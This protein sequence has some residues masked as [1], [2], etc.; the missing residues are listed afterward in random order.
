MS[1]AFNKGDIVYGI[2]GEKAEYIIA[3][4]GGHI[5]APIYEREDD[6]G[7]AMEESDTPVLWSK[8]FAI[9]PTEVLESKIGEL[10]L[11]LSEKRSELSLVRKQINEANAER[12]KSLALIKQ[13]ATLARIEEYL[14]GKF[15]F[16][17]TVPGYGKPFITPAQEA[18][19]NGGTESENRYSRP[20]MKLLTLFGDSKGDLSWRI[21]RYSDGSGG[22]D[23]VIPCHNME[24]AIEVIRKL[25]ADGVEAWRKQEKKHYGRA[26]DWS[27]LDASWIDVPDDVRQ[28]LEDTKRARLLDQRA[29]AEKELAD[30]Q[31]KLDGLVRVS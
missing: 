4:D 22:A 9:P 24:E 26:I 17:V 15:Q 8:V 20:P 21:S 3:H 11:E 2:H 27:S 1:K 7:H 13:N 10:E 5:V 16:F 30:A 29:K 25:Y 28:Y 6:F 31:A 12:Q 14:E 18:L 19:Q 23:E